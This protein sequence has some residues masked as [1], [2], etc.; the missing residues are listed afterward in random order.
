MDVPLA[1][2]EIGLSGGEQGGVW[3]VCDYCVAILIISETLV[4]GQKLL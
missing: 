1:G 2:G 4:Y 3:F